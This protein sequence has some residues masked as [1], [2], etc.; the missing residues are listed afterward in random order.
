MK[1]H[2]NAKHTLVSTFNASNSNFFFLSK[3]PIFIK[4][5][6]NNINNITPRITEIVIIHTA[7]CWVTGEPKNIV[8]IKVDLYPVF[9]TMLEGCVM[10]TLASVT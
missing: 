2:E 8:A 5:S 9:W 3:N 10:V 6:I 4:A 7:I 1:L